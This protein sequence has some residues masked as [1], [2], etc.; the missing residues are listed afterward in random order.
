MEKL[1]YDSLHKFLVSLGIILIAL[2]FVLLFYLLTGDVILISKL[3]YEGLSEYSQQALAQR[4]RITS[5]LETC[6]PWVTIVLIAVGILLIIIGIVRWRKVQNNLDVLIEAEAT[7]KSLE[8]SEMKNSEILAKTVTEVTDDTADGNIES[9]TAQDKIMKYME[10]E[11]AYFANFIPRKW[12]NQY[13]FK[14][15]L[16]IG[17]YEYDCIAVSKR[18]N[19]DL[20]FELKYWRGQR[21]VASYKRVFDQLYQAG[22]NYETLQHRNFRCILVIVAPKDEIKK[23]KERLENLYG[24]NSKYAYVKIIYKAEEDLN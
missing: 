4:E 12:K 24:E 19:I 17:K 1:E 13:Y 11:D 7:Q 10:I 9:T 15:N 21:T 2:P 8:A 23:H 16:R 3:E 18:D 22:Y 14:R 20:I 6:L 5:C